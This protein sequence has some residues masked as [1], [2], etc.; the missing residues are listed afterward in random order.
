MSGKEVLTLQFGNNSN[1]VGTHFW[2]M[3]FAYL[4]SMCDAKESKI[5]PCKIFRETSMCKNKQSH[6]PRM[7]SVDFK[8]SLG[9]LKQDGSYKVKNGLVNGSCVGGLQNEEV[10]MNE[11]YMVYK[12]EE[13]EKNE[14]LMN[15]H[16]KEIPLEK[17][18][19]IDS[20]VKTWTDYMT[21]TLNEN[22]VQVLRNM[23]D[24][25]DCFNFHELGCR[26]FH[27]LAA[28]FEDKLHYWIE[29]CNS[30]EGFM[31]FTDVHDGFTGVTSKL[32][33]ELHDEYRNKTVL[34]FLN[35]PLKENF[36]NKDP[37]PWLSTA[38]LFQSLGKYSSLFAVQGLN[39]NLMSK[40]PEDIHLPSLDYMSGST[41]HSAAVLA[42][43]ID[44]TTLPW[45]QTN[46]IEM[47]NFCQQ[48][49][50]DK[51]KMCA[52]SIGFPSV[53]NDDDYNLFEE[54][55]RKKELFGEFITSL[56]PFQ[57]SHNRKPLTQ[58]VVFQ[59]RSGAVVPRFEPKVLQSLGLYH[60]V[61]QGN[62]K[63]F[64]DYFL[65]RWYPPRSTMSKLFYT[66]WK[67]PLVYPLSTMIRTADGAGQTALSSLYTSSSFYNNLI[68]LI[69]KVENLNLNKLHLVQEYGFDNDSRRELVEDLYFLAK[70]YDLDEPYKE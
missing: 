13:I 14:F 23:F 54:L 45:R 26:Q 12:E 17:D 46:G 9:T 24:D 44:C 50:Q 63:N 67:V 33:E 62:P 22:S 6:F 29:E 49:S 60:D 57:N 59:N 52:T 43:A 40:G 42:S 35:F 58:C 39:C 25:N 16:G 3:Q 55:I 15:Y 70:D 20:K 34:P 7:I 51:F 4:E 53:K 36:A 19:D 30:M 31:I 1:H 11:E 66:D 21:Y 64:M 37:I 41:Y 68:E 27:D 38:L 2:N 56:Y 8:Q 10:E 47:R 69:E 65:D 18:F 5:D 61:F 48:V 32:L 28:E